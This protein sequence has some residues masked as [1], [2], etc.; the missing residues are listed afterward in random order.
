MKKLLFIL[1][2][3]LFIGTVLF[4]STFLSCILDEKK[5]EP[6]ETGLSA[7]EAITL[8]KDFTDYSFP[9]GVDALWFKFSSRDGS[10]LYIR[11]CAD[12]EYDYT[13]D[14]FVNIYV[15]DGKNLNTVKINGY[16]QIWINS[17]YINAYWMGTYH[18][19]VIPRSKNN[20]YKGTFAICFK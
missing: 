4:I 18:V 13:A 12:S 1:K 7:P 20:A 5:E 17:N 8:N 14:V 3:V 10:S 15:Y 11:D 6:K 16:S 19:E 9:E 2:S